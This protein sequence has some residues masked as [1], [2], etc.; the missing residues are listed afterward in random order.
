MVSES[1]TAAEFRAQHKGHDSERDLQR[2]VCEWLDVQDVVYYA[3]PNGQYR[4]GQAME[5]GLQ[6]GVPDL[7]IPVPTDE[8][9]GLYI[10]LKQPKRYT[11]KSQREWLDRLTDLGHACRV[12]RSVDE[13]EDVV[14][15]Y[16]SDRIEAEALWPH[17]R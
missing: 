11:R 15:A 10:E 9:G 2:A 12:C 3:V 8:Y 7:C 16:R 6:K 5:A 13:V 1:M 14:R 17:Q 4:P